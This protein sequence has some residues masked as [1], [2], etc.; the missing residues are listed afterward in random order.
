MVKRWSMHQEDITTVN[1]YAPNTRAPNYIKQI[2]TGKGSKQQ[3]INSWRLYYPTL[4]NGYIIQTDYQVK[5]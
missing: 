3:Y 1:I 4:N 5:Q 2:L